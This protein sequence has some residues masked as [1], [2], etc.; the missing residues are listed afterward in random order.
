[1]HV[2][3]VGGIRRRQ[4][5]GDSECAALQERLEPS[6]RRSGVVRRRS[7]WRGFAAD[8]AQP[9]RSAGLVMLY[10]RHN[11]GRQPACAHQKAAAPAID[12]YARHLGTQLATAVGSHTAARAIA[13]PLGAVHRARHAARRKRAAPAHMT[14]EHQSLDR[15]LHAAPVVAAHAQRRSSRP[16]AATHAGSIERRSR[17]VRAHRHA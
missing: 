5:G 12:P 15:R 16:E 6:A 2:L 7:A 8:H 11:A 14:V 3:G 13:H 10:R 1:M 9:A 4:F 17:P